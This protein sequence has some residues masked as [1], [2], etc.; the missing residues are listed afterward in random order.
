M[1]LMVAAPE[2]TSPVAMCMSREKVESKGTDYEALFSFECVCNKSPKQE[3]KKKKKEAGAR[4]TGIFAFQGPPTPKPIRRAKKSDQ[5]GRRKKRKSAARS[6]PCLVVPG[7]S[8]GIVVV[9]SVSY[10]LFCP[11][12]IL[13]PHLS[14]E[15]KKLRKKKRGQRVLVGDQ[16][17]WIP[18]ASLL[19][20][21]SF[22]ATG[23]FQSAQA[24]MRSWE[25]PLISPIFRVVRTRCLKCPKTR[26]ACLL[27]V[28]KN[29]ARCL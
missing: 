3:I 13:L 27:S 12:P 9:L 25:S 16:S 2:E 15:K 21:S 20:D 7:S 10:V 22:D 19:P 17:I 14:T 5:A 23:L 18:L 1:E 11:L 26:R 6:P 8:L 28:S 4:P 29:R 24:G